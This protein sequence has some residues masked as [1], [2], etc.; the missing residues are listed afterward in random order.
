MDSADAVVL[1]LAAAATAFAAAAP[2]RARALLAEVEQTPGGHETPYYAR[3]LAAMVRI[4]LAA[5]DPRLQGGSLKAW[6]RSSRFASMPSAPPRPTRRTR[7]RTRRG[8]GALR[9]S[10]RT[11]AAV[12][13]RPRVRLRPAR[14]GPLPGRPR[15][16][17]GR[18]TAPECARS[19]SI[20]GLQTCSRGNGVAAEPSPNPSVLRA[21]QGNPTHRSPETP[22]GRKRRNRLRAQ[23]HLIRPK[24]RAASLNSNLVPACSA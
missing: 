4:A 7:R 2:E 24:L 20:D 5:D 21:T 16:A 9:R 18:R 13:E 23:L 15:Q 11:L 19:S 14:P 10:G 1:A 6:S 22:T 12:R 3:Q 17:R 8:G